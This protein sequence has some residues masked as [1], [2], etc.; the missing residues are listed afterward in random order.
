MKVKVGLVKCNTYDSDELN[1]ALE[2]AMGLS[3]GINVN[4]MKLLLK[5]NILQDTDPGKAIST[6]PEFVRAVIKYMQKE[7]AAEIYVGDSPG[8]QKP[9]YNG[10]KSGIR[11][12]CEETGAKWIDFTT[13]KTTII[14]ENGKI[15]KEFKVTAIIDEVDM[16]ISLPKMK[17]HQLMYFTGAAK[18]LFGLLPGLSKSTYHV[19]YP[20][21]YNFGEMILDLLEAVNP[22]Y[23]IMDAVIGMEGPGPGNGYPKPVKLI[24]ASPNA[25]ALDITASS[26]I[27]YDPMTIPTNKLGLRRHSGLKH[28]SDISIEGE[29]LSDVKIDDYKLLG[30]KKFQNII[31]DL[32]HFRIFEKYQQ[33]RKPRPYFIEEKC[34]K[35]G[36]CIK[37]C[38]SDANWFEKGPNGKFVAVD[39]NKCIRCY[40]C[41]EICPVDAIEIRK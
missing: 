26:V 15:Q 17:T 31:F 8:F 7:G 5:P 40:C 30:E 4:G 39:Y 3:G 14:A 22:A 28:I 27:G 33:K 18:N 2:E 16:V 35:C 36:E 13:G 20:N 23:S 10:R 24:I 25:I 34:I 38:A 21:R 1:K 11:Q 12:V 19:T 41:H 29:A 6:H 32:F 9:G 37:I